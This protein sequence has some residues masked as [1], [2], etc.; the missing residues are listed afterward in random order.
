M[1]YYVLYVLLCS[2]IQH[3]IVYA[4]R[5]VYSTVQ[6]RCE[7]IGLRFYCKL[8]SSCGLVLEIIDSSRP[9]PAAVPVPS[10]GIEF[11]NTGPFKLTVSQ[12]NQVGGSKGDPAA[13]L[14]ISTM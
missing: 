8:D 13:L 3:T 1:N 5:C 14:I 6:Y 11:T 9:V 10:R 2:V 7:L 12:W 4:Y